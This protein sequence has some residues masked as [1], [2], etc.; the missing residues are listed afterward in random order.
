MYQTRELHLPVI[1]I[2]S[3][4]WLML[5]L[6][7]CSA[8]AGGG[9]DKALGLVLR[10]IGSALDVVGT[11]VKRQATKSNTVQLTSSDRNRTLFAHGKS[12][13]RDTLLQL[14]KLAFCL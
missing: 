4:T 9:G 8:L 14:D 10:S 1:C 3:A 7:V 2:S 13:L 11:P 6:A 12:P 5:R